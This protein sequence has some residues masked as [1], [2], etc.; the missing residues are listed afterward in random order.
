MSSTVETQITVKN[1]PCHCSRCVTLCQRNPGWMTPL[2]A[3][4]AIE[5]GYASRLMKDWLEPCTEL[6][7]EK[8]IFVLAPA[9]IGY[10][11]REAPDMPFSAIFT[12]WCKGKCTFLR[13]GRCE[14]HDSA[15][16]PRQCRE[17]YGCV[18]NEDCPDNYEMARLWNTRDGRNVVKQWKRVLCG[19]ATESDSGSFSSKSAASAASLRV[20]DAAIR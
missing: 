4:L 9:S 2:E 18:P 15:F 16:K 8:R 11:G 17:A 10:E 14:I 5:A 12:G 19:N 6:K 7:N 1:T 13:K 3:R 20:T